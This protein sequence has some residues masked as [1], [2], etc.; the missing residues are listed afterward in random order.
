MQDLRDPRKATNYPASVAEYD[1]NGRPVRT[2]AGGPAVRH[3]RINCVASL[4]LTIYV[5]ICNG[6]DAEP[7]SEKV[8][9]ASEQCAEMVAYAIECATRDK[10]AVA[11][12]PYRDQHHL[13]DRLTDQFTASLVGISDRLWPSAPDP[14]EADRA[15]LAAE[16]RNCSHGVSFDDDCA[17]CE[18]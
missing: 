17:E 15:A 12:V 3:F 14:Y 6:E 4:A 18:A 8:S 13:A 16:P 10:A 11:A 5:A 1:A 9:S 2:R 7:L